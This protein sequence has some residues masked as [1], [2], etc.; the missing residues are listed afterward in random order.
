MKSN[1]VLK[2]NSCNVPVSSYL[3]DECGHSAKFLQLS[4]SNSQ[5]WPESL[6]TAPVKP[7]ESSHGCEGK[8]RISSN[9]NYVPG[10][11]IFNSLMVNGDI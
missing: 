3:T 2:L 5:A 8:L 4:L 10:G 7:F 9:R 11:V 6:T 1:S